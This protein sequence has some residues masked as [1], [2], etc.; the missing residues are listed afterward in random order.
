MNDISVK[1]ADF[2]NA[3]LTNAENATIDSQNFANTSTIVAALSFIV[4]GL[5]AVVL[6]VVMGKR[7]TNPLK[8]LTEVAGKVSMG[9]LDH[10]IDIKTKDEIADLGEAFQRMIN[11][12]KMTVALSKESEETEKQ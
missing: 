4:I 10:T 3:T 12:F 8:K 9:E 5:V 11:A 7:I 2:R 6:A 1:L